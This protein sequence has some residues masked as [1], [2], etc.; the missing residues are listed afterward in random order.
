MHV[1]GL[2]GIR[3]SEGTR[4]RIALL[5]SSTGFSTVRRGRASCAGAFAGDGVAPVRIDT[6]E[7]IGRN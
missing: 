3:P 7:W 5:E 2:E 4:R 1:D 6:Q